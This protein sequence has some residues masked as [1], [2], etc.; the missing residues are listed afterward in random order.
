MG[1]TNVDDY[2]KKERLFGKSEEEIKTWLKKE[3]RDNL[4]EVLSEIKEEQRRDFFY[5]LFE[6]FRYVRKE[7]IKL[8]QREGLEEPDTSHYKK[9]LEKISLKDAG[10][11]IS[12]YITKTEK[13][14]IT[15]KNG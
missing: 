10:L 2:I 9:V 14:K 4:R 11:D 13:I 5:D 8:A 1:Y 15:D 7:A 12:K 3:L 6:S